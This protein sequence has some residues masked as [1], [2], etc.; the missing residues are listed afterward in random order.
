[1]RKTDTDLNY[2]SLDIRWYGGAI[3]EG[4]PAPR[5][6]LAIVAQHRDVSVTD[7]KGD[8]IAATRRTWNV[9]RV[10]IPTSSPDRQP[11]RRTDRVGA[12]SRIVRI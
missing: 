1:M 8:Q 10:D 7:V 4:G 12:H 11:T 3:K 5:E 2:L 9:R 6:Y